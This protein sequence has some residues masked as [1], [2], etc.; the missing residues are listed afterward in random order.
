MKNIFLTFFIVFSSINCFAT[1]DDTKIILKQIDKRFE[2][3]DKQFELMKHNIDKRFEQVDKRFEQVNKQFELMKHNIDKRFEYM[4]N[5]LY[6]IMLMI[7]SSPF[8]A[9]YLRDKREAED[10]K[11]F[12]AIKGI[13]FTLRELAQDDEKI[14]RSLRAASLL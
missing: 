2:Q 8:I 13:I 3:V 7:F 12:D 14:A 9:L 5:I 1:T 10:R 11:N 6:G 4:N